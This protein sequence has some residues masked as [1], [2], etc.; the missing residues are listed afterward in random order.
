MTPTAEQVLLNQI[1]VYAGAL[2]RASRWHKSQESI[3]KVS[4]KQGEKNGGD[5]I[6]EFYCYIRILSD[7]IHNYDL[8]FKPGKSPNR[9]Y[10]P[11]APANKAGWPYFL[12][13]D[14]TTKE[15]KYQVCPGTHVNTRYDT[16][17]HPDISFQK[18]G[19]SGD[20]QVDDVLLIMDS[21]FN[22]SDS[23]KNKV[24]KTQL[25]DVSIMIQDLEVED[26]SKEDIKFHDLAAFKG[27][28]LLTNRGAHSTNAAYNKRYNIIE[29]EHFSV[30]TSFKIIG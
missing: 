25:S 29:V 13:L 3:A 1:N 4:L 9:Y 8:V 21:K 18:A 19:T 26:A 14:R 24:A 17:R 27:N 30:G 16:K 12:L 6:Y 7:L 20:P 10:F 15:E 5:Y 22:R 2:K 28:C 23:E 11:Q